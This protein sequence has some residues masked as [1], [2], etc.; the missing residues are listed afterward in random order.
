MSERDIISL[1]KPT[2]E[3][4]AST[5]APGMTRIRFFKIWTPE[6]GSYD[7][8]L[9]AYKR[10]PSMP[11]EQIPRTAVGFGDKVE[12]VDVDIPSSELE[13]LP[14]EPIL[15]GDGIR[16]LRR[17]TAALI[18]FPLN[19][20]TQIHNNENPTSHP[21]SGNANSPIS[22]VGQPLTDRQLEEAKKPGV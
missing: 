20:P 6:P 8:V 16:V 1:S 3:P 21:S 19:T 5:P 14:E 11:V 18:V 7:A 17:P 22:F 4:L 15:R 2:I 13:Q 9:E 10:A 12:V